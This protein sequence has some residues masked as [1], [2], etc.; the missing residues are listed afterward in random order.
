MIAVVMKILYTLMI[1]LLIM[2][3]KNRRK[4]RAINSGRGSVP[5]KNRRLVMLE[6]RSRGVSLEGSH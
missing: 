4:D 6:A 3:K 2:K 1:V 5:M